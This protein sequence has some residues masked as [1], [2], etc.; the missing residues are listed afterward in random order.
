LA[1]AQHVY[2]IV[3]DKLRRFRGNMAPTAGGEK[4][5]GAAKLQEILEELRAIHRALK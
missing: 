1:D 2:E 3:A 5:E 4:E